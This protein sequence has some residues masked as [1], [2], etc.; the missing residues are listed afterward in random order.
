MHFISSLWLLC[1]RM[2]HCQKWGLECG[3]ARWRA[4]EPEEGRLN[5]EWM[6]IQFYSRAAD[7]L[8]SWRATRQL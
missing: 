1:L 2:N 7:P 8:F 5:A 4:I 3:Y 6:Q